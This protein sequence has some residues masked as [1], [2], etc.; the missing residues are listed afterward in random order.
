M[1]MKHIKPYEML[2]N[3]SKIRTIEI[4]YRQETRKNK[5]K[6]NSRRTEIRDQRENK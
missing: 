3:V 6:P 1:K 5:V 2:Q 4:E